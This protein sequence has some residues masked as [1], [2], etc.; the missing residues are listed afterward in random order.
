MG[1]LTHWALVSWFQGLQAI[2]KLLPNGRCPQ[3]FLSLDNLDN[4]LCV[5]GLV[6]MAVKNPCK[7]FLTSMSI[8]N[9]SKNTNCC[10]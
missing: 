10:P 7:I 1:G 6:V 5:G 9:P 8:A 3:R 2:Y 4:G